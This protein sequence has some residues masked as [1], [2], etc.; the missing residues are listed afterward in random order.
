M[1]R[2]GGADLVEWLLPL[3]DQMRVIYMSGFMDESTARHGLLER[4]MYFLQK[5]F[6]RNDLLVKVREVLDAPAPQR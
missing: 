2:V 4:G 1:H 6:S 5:P 3:Q